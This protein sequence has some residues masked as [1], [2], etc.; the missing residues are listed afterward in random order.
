LDTAGLAIQALYPHANLPGIINNYNATSILS[1]VTDSYFAKIDHNFAVNNRLSGSYR[2]KTD[3]TNNAGTLARALDGTAADISPSWAQ[4]LNITD[5]HIISSSFLNHFTLG[6]VR[7][8]FLNMP[9][10]GRDSGIVILGSFGPGRPSPCFSDTY[11]SPPI[12]NPC[13]FSTW[14]RMEGHYDMDVTD[15]L[16]RYVGKHAFKWGGRIG[17]Y[18]FNQRTTP[19]FTG[20]PDPTLACWQC[21]GYYQ[22]S[23]LGTSLR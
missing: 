19:S 13:G 6:L 2:F 18:G 17:R 3:V 22:F 23:S 11:N 20:A 15:N 16:T 10:T 12:N 8:S 5:D 9:G 21:S 1:E 14:D 4:N 7:I